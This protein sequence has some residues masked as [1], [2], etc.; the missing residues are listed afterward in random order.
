MRRLAAQEIKDRLTAAG[1]SFDDTLKYGELWELYK[2]STPEEKPAIEEPVQ[3]EEAPTPAPV[4]P[5]TPF[6]LPGAPDFDTTMP[7]EWRNK[8]T[9]KIGSLM[10]CREISEGVEVY[11]GTK[12]V[13]AYTKAVH[14]ENYAQ[15]AKQFA[16]KNNRNLE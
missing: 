6:I 11:Q 2:A 15:L 14:G 12:F 9:H 1:I 5:V 10:R 13:R 8:K 3:P 16:D 4:A 7:S